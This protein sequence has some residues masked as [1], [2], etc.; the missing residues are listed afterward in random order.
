MSQQPC[1]K[2]GG[3]KFVGR[4]DVQPVYDPETNKTELVATGDETIHCKACGKL[5]GTRDSVYGDTA[6]PDMVVFG[7]PEALKGAKAADGS[8]D[9]DEESGE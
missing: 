6:Q 4:Q 8:D 5:Q 2:C 1:A 7:E 3:T 9:A